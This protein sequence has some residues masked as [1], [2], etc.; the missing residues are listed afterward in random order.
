MFKKLL[1][2]LGL[3]EEV[4]VRIAPSPTGFLHI[5]TART[6][7][8]NWLF[9]RHHGGKFILRIEDTDLERSEK[10]FEADIIESLKWLGLSWDEGPYYQS[11]R[12][13]IYEKYLNKIW[14]DEKAFFCQHSEQELE[15][16]RKKQLANKMPIRHICS[17]RNKSLRK[18]ILRF[19]SEFLVEIQIGAPKK[20]SRASRKLF[21]ENPREVPFTDVIRGKVTCFDH[22]EFL[23]DF[24]LAK[25]LRAPLYNFAV[26]VDDEEMKISHVIRGEDHISNTFKQILIQQALGFKT[27]PKYAHLPLILDPD[28]SKMSKRYSAT[29]IQEY[30]DQGYLAE[31]MVNFMT[32]LGWHP[33]GAEEIE[34]MPI[35]E[36]IEKFTLERVQKGG[37]VFD[38][39]KLDWLNSQ[40]LKEK[41]NE[42]LLGLVKEFYGQEL[43]GSKELLLKM[44]KVGK[45]R[46]NKLSDFKELRAQFAWSDYD[47]NLLIWKNTPKEKTYE[48]LRVVKE[49]IRG[50]LA[51][52]LENG[53]LESNLMGLANARGRG[54]VLW[55]L[56]VA[57]SG[58]D[59]SPGP[60]EIME[61]IGKEEA[62]RRIEV[63]I[64][65]IES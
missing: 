47:K 37:A 50:A 14:K 36:I 61:V 1:T 20:P 48:S 27:P 35:S 55:P 41:N 28:R 22:R 2:T 40:Y 56:R 31:A 39:Q 17:D 52:E 38:I 53:S 62:L 6:A 7:L 19:N 25:D 24:S 58:K 60:F 16:E 42:D 3:K 29:S 51:Q 21:K 12:L 30:R 11:E 5:G 65:K 26:V 34:K 8:F 63:A 57:L 64:Q 46:M 54:E 59:K 13:D 15:E 43:G 10:R 23:G 32:L 18:G 4:R 33:S 49:V 9:A 45:S 44:I